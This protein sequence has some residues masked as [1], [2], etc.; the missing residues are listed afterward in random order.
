[1]IF[2][3]YLLI[4]RYFEEEDETLEESYQPAP[5]SPGPNAKKK[6][7]DEE[8]DPLDAFMLGIEQEVNIQLF[9]K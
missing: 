1:M 5:G 8:D 2:I 6:D 4:H 3:N 9:F 7:S